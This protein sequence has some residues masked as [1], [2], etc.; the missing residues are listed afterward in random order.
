MQPQLENATRRVAGQFSGL[1]ISVQPHFAFLYIQ[2][3]VEFSGLGISVQP[4]LKVASGEIIDE[5]GGIET[6][7]GFVLGVK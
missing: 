2:A 4:Q 3:L 1:G 6:V 7:R 5:F